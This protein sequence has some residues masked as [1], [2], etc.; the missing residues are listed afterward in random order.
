[1]VDSF[2][3]SQIGPTSKNGPR[4]AGLDKYQVAG[5]IRQETVF[6]P[7]AKSGANAYGL[8]QL[9]LPTAQDGRTKV[10]L[11]DAQRRPRDLFDPSLN[12]ELGTAYLKD[13]F[14]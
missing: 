14:D 2:I 10:R 3:R 1:M 9:L 8:M 11:D 6:D 5:F 4:T 13:Q 7:R 12:I